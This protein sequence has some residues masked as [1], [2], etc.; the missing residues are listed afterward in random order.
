[1]VRVMAFRAALADAY[2]TMVDVVLRGD[3]LDMVTTEPALSPRPRARA[4]RISARPSAR[5]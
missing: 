1:M 2:D 3:P 5:C 4:A